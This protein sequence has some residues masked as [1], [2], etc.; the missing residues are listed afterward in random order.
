MA[1]LYLAY[2]SNLNVEQMVYRCPDA[3]PVGIAELKGYHLLFK[4]SKTGSYLTIERRE[5]ESVPVVV[6]LVSEANENAL[7]RYEGCPDFYYKKFMDIEYTDLQSRAVK[8][9]EAFV[10]IM[11]EDRKC[12][13][14]SKQYLE[15]CAEGYRNFGFDSSL[16][17]RAYLE[18]KGECGV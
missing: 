3:T 5:D 9:G 10:Y 6:W 1:R 4:G 7:D 13:I 8:K 18:S 11:H 15:T 12:G 2:G 14:P 16:L 17:V